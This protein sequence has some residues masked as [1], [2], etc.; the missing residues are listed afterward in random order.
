MLLA[1]LEPDLQVPVSCI[2]IALQRLR[3]CVT[4]QDSSS[5]ED[6]NE[7]THAQSSVTERVFQVED[8]A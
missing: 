1:V 6:G 3:A 2:W 8:Q 5:V 4:D 7:S